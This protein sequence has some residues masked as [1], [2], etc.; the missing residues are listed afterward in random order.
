MPGTVLNN[1]RTL[2]P[3]GHFLITMRGTQNM[4]WGSIGGVFIGEG[5]GDSFKEINSIVFAPLR[6]GT[7]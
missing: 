6:G 1:I 4:D 3:G 2:P 7:Y 5:E